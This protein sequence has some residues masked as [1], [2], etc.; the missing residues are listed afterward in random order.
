M[1]KSVLF[2]IL[3]WLCLGSS[4]AQFKS[5]EPLTDVSDR[6]Y[7]L[8]GLQFLG[9]EIYS[10]SPEGVS[11]S[12]NEGITWDALSFDPKGRYPIFIAKD[13]LKMGMITS[14]ARY[15][16]DGIQLHFS[17]DGGLQWETNTFKID[18]GWFCNTF[19]LTIKDDHIVLTLYNDMYIST[20]FGKTFKNY[21][22]YGNE[23]Q[24]QIYHIDST[25]YI[26]DNNHVRKSKNLKNFQRVNLPGLGNIE[27]HFVYKNQIVLTDGVSIK[28]FDGNNL[29]PFTDFNID[30]NFE[31][32]A[33]DGKSMFFYY[34]EKVI[35]VDLSTFD[36]VSI[37][38]EKYIKLFEEN[39]FIH[40]H[41][42]FVYYF[43]GQRLNKKSIGSPSSPAQNIS[44]PYPFY[45]NALFYAFDWI[46][47]KGE[48]LY[49]SD[50]NNPSWNKSAINRTKYE[51]FGV[52][53][54]SE[55]LVQR[56]SPA[57]YK[58]YGQKVRNSAF[59]MDI[60]SLESVGNVLF[61]RHNDGKLYTLHNGIL[62][63]I[64]V[65]INRVWNKPVF[66]YSQKKYI[67]HESNQSIVV[68]DDGYQWSVLPGKIPEPFISIRVLKNG[69]FIAISAKN[70]YLYSAENEKWD[71]FTT[72]N[73]PFQSNIF[74]GLETYDNTVIT[75]VIYKGVYVT[76]IEDVRWTKWDEG[77]TDFKFI[78]SLGGDSHMVLLIGNQVHM[79]P[80]IELPATTSVNHLEFAEN[81]I[82]L[83]PN[84]AVHFLNIHCDS[85]ETVCRFTI[86][87][88]CGNNMLES[89]QH[90]H[91]VDISQFPNGMYVVQLHTLKN[92][93]QRTFIVA[94]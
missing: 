82:A 74:V 37:A 51:D 38:Y 83:Y 59:S 26:V 5:L 4:M 58:I 11:V 75:A 53:G 69:S 71:K 54:K 68:S 67:I 34:E 13:S 44:H 49:F 36:Q 7:Y 76:N 27:N 10:F 94:K 1:K 25:F 60:A 24:N 14:S 87:D 63:W 12:K 79:R 9:D 29:S 50:L 31:R 91:Q 88:M 66:A 47:G 32:T 2:M 64:E 18:W 22:F 72:A 86:S 93:Y 70:I 73:L 80:Y 89:N 30:L 62:P 85:V 40:F 90:Q 17:N 28:I 39:V 43:D 55:V 61:A 8:N 92:T 78:K 84:P 6:S 45:V 56:P 48:H 57:I 77:L 33:T 35:M 21:D 81:A 20:D 3:S 52:V 15:F 19:S 41:N 23:N 16:C 42:G 46:W 65:S